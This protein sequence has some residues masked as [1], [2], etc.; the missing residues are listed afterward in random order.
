MVTVT[1]MLQAILTVVFAFLLQIFE[2]YA[3]PCGLRLES[4]ARLWIMLGIRSRLLGIRSTDAR[5]L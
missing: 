5:N 1:S 3:L 4:V 2:L